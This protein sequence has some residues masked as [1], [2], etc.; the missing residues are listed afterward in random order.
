VLTDDDLV[1]AHDD[2]ARLLLLLAAQVPRMGQH[3][4]VDATA[5]PAYSNEMRKAKSNSDARWSARTKRRCR[6]KAGG[7]VE[8]YRDY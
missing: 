8:E 4:A 7:G 3:L 1:G 2:T 5:A 6:H